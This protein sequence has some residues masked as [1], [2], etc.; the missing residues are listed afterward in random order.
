M[1]ILKMWPTIFKQN[2]KELALHTVKEADE[3]NEL[4]N[5]N[6]KKITLIFLISIAVSIIVGYLMSKIITKNIVKPLDISVN[7]LDI[8][9]SGDFT[10][11]VPIELKREKMK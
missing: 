6:Y 9:S 8:L 4:N 11:E 10:S 7:Y 3:I 2:L 5:E 1:K